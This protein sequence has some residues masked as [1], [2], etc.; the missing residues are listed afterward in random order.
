MIRKLSHNPVTGARAPGYYVLS[1]RKKY[2]KKRKKWM[3]RNMGR[4]NTLEGAQKRLRQV[5]VFKH[6]LLRRKK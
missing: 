5:E 6:M 3:Y 1:D 2:N 4:Y